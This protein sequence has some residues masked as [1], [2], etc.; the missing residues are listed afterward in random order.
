MATQAR[1]QAAIR[2]RRVVVAV[3]VVSRDVLDGVDV[4]I[5]SGTRPPRYAFA[6]DRTKTG[7][8]CTLAA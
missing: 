4:H 2:K 6:T 3:M 8:E 5:L 1:A 7:A